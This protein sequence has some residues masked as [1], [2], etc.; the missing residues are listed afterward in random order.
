MNHEIINRVCSC[1][2]TISPEKEAEMEEGLKTHL[3]KYYPKL[4]KQRYG[5]D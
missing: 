5:E 1:G 3:K 4:Y 2:E